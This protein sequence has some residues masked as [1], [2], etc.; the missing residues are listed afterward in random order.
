MDAVNYDAVV[1]L[2]E[3][4]DDIGRR[5]AFG[6]PEW[7]SPYVVSQ[8]DGS[9]QRVPDFLDSQHTIETPLLREFHAA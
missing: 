1:Y 5:F 9:Y 7:A 4:V 2:W 8:L 6:S 3:R